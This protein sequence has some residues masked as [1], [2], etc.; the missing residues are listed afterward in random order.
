MMMDS[1]LQAHIAFALLEAGPPEALAEAGTLAEAITTGDSTLTFWGGLGYAT[2]AGVR[3]AQGELETAERVAR[4]ALASVAAIGP[5]AAAFLGGILAAQGKAAEALTVVEDWLIRL[6]QEGQ[7]CFMDV[8]L[9]LVTAEL[10]RAQGREQDARR[11]IERAAGLIEQRAAR[12]PDPE[13][14]ESYLHGVRDHARVF[15]LWRGR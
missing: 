8:K 14:R 5:L 6:E 1:V 10:Q 7:T 9:L 12:I 4:R 13:I 15:E 2:L 11:A 3:A